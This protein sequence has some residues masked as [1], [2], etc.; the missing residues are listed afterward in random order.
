VQELLNTFLIINFV[1]LGS[2]LYLWR[3]DFTR[4][5]A[6]EKESVLPEYQ[7]LGTSEGDEARNSLAEEEDSGENEPAKEHRDAVST[8]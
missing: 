2:V 8:Y 6:D 1:Q 4:R 3:L 7:P 5:Q